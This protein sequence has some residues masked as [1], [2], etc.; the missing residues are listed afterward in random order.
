MARRNR[1][2]STPW[3][4]LRMFP[5]STP[6]HNIAN[7]ALAPSCGNT[8]LFINDRRKCRSRL[9]IAPVRL[10]RFESFSN[11]ILRRYEGI[12]KRIGRIMIVMGE[13]FLT[14]IS[15]ADWLESLIFLYPLEKDKLNVTRKERQPDKNWKNVNVIWFFSLRWIWSNV[16]DISTM[17][18]DTR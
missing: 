10:L 6:T 9:I 5:Y 16:N 2:V 8:L 14:T 11:K 12:V 1:D 7:I 15:S 17:R 3:I 4:S 13:I 18:T